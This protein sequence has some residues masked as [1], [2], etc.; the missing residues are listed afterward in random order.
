MRVEGGKGKAVA[1]DFSKGEMS[2]RHRYA[3]ES[4]CAFA[5]TDEYAAYIE[6][7]LVRVCPRTCLCRGNHHSFIPFPL[8]CS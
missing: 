4:I 5:K 7:A 2:I 3:F 6:D 8:I 1:E